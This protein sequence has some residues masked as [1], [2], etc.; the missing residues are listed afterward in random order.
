[1][2][3][4]RWYNCCAALRTCRPDTFSLGICNGCQLM[5]LLGWVPATA[6]KDGVAAQLQDLQQPRFVHNKSGRFE[7]RW[8]SVSIAEDSPSMWLQ[9]M[10]GSTVGVWAAH[11]EGQVLFPDA[12]VQAAVLEKKLAP[13]RCDGEQGVDST[14]CWGAGCWERIICWGSRSLGGCLVGFLAACQ[15]LRSPFWRMSFTSTVGIV[16][17]ALPH[18]V[19][20]TTNPCPASKPNAFVCGSD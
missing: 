18:N 15:P 20:H 17:V 10:G 3:A 9:G 5:A 2:A 4:G 6:A 14:V 8:I 7:S 13:I 12:A 1:M 11:G 19:V 16:G